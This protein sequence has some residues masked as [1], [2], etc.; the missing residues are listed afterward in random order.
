VPPNKAT[1]TYE[2]LLQLHLKL[3]IAASAVWM[4]KKG[5]ILSP[6]DGFTLHF[7]SPTSILGF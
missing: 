2:S 7:L 5:T 6:V 4:K 3:Q 1:G